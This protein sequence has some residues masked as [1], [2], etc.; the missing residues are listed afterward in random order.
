M[1]VWEMSF[2]ELLMGARLDGIALFHFSL[3][4]F[5]FWLF[6]GFLVFGLGI[7]LFLYFFFSVF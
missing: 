4:L 1:H 7:F 5:C 3:L 6:S 2:I